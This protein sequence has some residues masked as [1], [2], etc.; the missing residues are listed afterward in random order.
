MTVRSS[1]AIAALAACLVAVVLLYLRWQSQP[2]G[3]AES[4]DDETAAPIPG[5]PA[6]A[7][8]ESVPVLAEA[9]PV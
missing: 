7:V 6:P 1:L 3:L 4:I 9:A 2:D 5:D 8:E